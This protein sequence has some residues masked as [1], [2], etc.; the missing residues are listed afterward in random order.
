MSDIETILK[1]AKAFAFRH[2]LKVVSD[3]VEAQDLAAVLE[4][5]PASFKSW[6]YGKRVKLEEAV[7]DKHGI[8]VERLR[9][10]KNKPK[11]CVHVANLLDVIELRKKSLAVVLLAKSPE[12]SSASSSAAKNFDPSSSKEIVLKPST[13]SPSNTSSAAEAIVSRTATTKSEAEEGPVVSSALPDIFSQL[14]LNVFPASKPRT[15]ALARRLS[16]HCG[17]AFRQEQVM[18]NLKLSAVSSYLVGPEDLLA[19]EA[20]EGQEQRSL[21]LVMIRSLSLEL[22]VSAYSHTNAYASFHCSLT[23]KANAIRS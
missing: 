6:W 14:N 19:W 21:Y 2:K 3:F 9:Q 17:P 20:V 15:F 4:E 22:G 5:D 11:A 13:A 10:Q 1:V 16:I 18:S 7:K 12:K 8:D 23:I